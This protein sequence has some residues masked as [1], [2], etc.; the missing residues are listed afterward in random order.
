M[1]TRQNRALPDINDQQGDT[2]IFIDPS[3]K[4][5]EQTEEG[6]AAYCSRYLNPIRMQSQKLKRASPAFEEMLQPTEQFRTIRRRHLVGK[7]PPGVKYVLDLTPPT[8]GEDAVYLTAS[9]SCSEGVRFWHQAC[10][11]W[12][13]SNRLVGGSEEWSSRLPD[14]TKAD[15]AILE[16]SPIRHRSAIE[17]LLA[18]VQGLDVNFDSA[19]KVWSTTVVA[20]YFGITQHTCTFLTDCL[21]TWIRVEPNFYFIEVNPEVTLR[22]AA[23][24]ENEDLVHDTFAILVGEEALDASRRNRAV[25]PKA[26]YSTHGRKKEG[27]PESWLQRIEY[28]SKSFIDRNEKE[29]EG[30]LAQNMQWIENLPTVQLLKNV[31]SPEPKAIA[32]QLIKLLKDHVHHALFA[33]LLE[34][35]DA[36]WDN[37]EGCW[38]LKPRKDKA[39]RYEDLTL[40]QRILTRNFWYKLRHT[41]IVRSQY[42][43]EQLRLHEDALAKHQHDPLAKQYMSTA[44]FAT[45]NNI[46]STINTGQKYVDGLSHGEKLSPPSQPPGTLSVENQVLSTDR[47]SLDEDTLCEQST[48]EGGRDD[49]STKEE[50]VMNPDDPN[51]YITRVNFDPSEPEK[52][53]WE[54]SAESRSS[55]TL[56]DPPQIP[57]LNLP[58]RSRGL[59]A[60]HKSES[61]APNETADWWSSQVTLPVRNDQSERT[62]VQQRSQDNTDDNTNSTTFFNLRNIDSNRFVGSSFFDLPQFSEE[63][64]TYIREFASSKLAAA[65]STTRR[66]PYVPSLTRTLTCLTEDEWKYLPLWAN[67]YDDETGAIYSEVPLEAAPTAG[68]STAGPSIHTGDSTY[69]SSSLGS[70]RSDY[71]MMSDVGSRDTSFNISTAVADGYSDQ[72]FRGKIYTPGSTIAS[73]VDDDS[74]FNHTDEDEELA[75]AMVASFEIA[76]ITNQQASTTTQVMHSA[77]SSNDCYDDLFSGNSE[78]DEELLEDGYM[79][80]ST[81]KA[82]DFEHLEKEEFTNGASVLV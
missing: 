36:K 4:Q 55:A 19:V 47:A 71:D 24:M 79:S 38:R 46:S 77:P 82:D 12:N 42:P 67:G 30:L 1:S 3:N 58:Y 20:E 43:G 17:R 80:D 73:D 23:A 35:G 25:G 16:Y 61:N 70:A 34:D 37:Q 76:Q 57:T 13:V 63:V 65:D 33:V 60:L 51:R 54:A 28:A 48:T 2:F 14:S 5:P 78:E 64:N 72:L 62:Y 74:V 41:C 15:D 8:E 29:V 39:V 9:L 18:A 68:F 7:L 40:C 21:L 44:F 53:A 32:K 75:R 81:E 10:E 59:D 31:T 11:I 66:E 26:E 45:M 6:Y 27:L 49:G 50:P 56:R 52:A 22:I 69:S